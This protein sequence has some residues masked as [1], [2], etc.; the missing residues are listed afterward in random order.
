MDL[1]FDP[2]AVWIWEKEG[3]P[4]REP[5]ARI[6]EPAADLC[7]PTQAHRISFRAKGRRL[8]TKEVPVHDYQSIDVL[9]RPFRFCNSGN[10]W[11]P[12]GEILFYL[13]LR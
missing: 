5:V 3:F 1:L 9:L 7:R 10:A 6:A 2:M 8:K 13:P 12:E 11:S 4:F